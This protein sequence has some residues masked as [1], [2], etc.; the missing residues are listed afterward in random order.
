MAD[1]KQLAIFCHQMDKALHAGVDV[2][3]AF[4]IIQDDNNRSLTAAISRTYE[5]LRRGQSLS[6]SMRADESAYSSELVDLIYITEQTG[7]TELAFHRMAERFD[8]RLQIERKLKQAAIYPT[9]V[10]IVAIVSLL[11]VAYVYHMLPAA[12]ASILVFFGIIAAILFMKYS[13]D[14][15]SR[16]SRIVGN[17]LIRVPLLGKRIMQAELADLADNLAVFYSCGTGVDKALEFCA[18]ALRHEALREKVL[19]AASYVRRG[20][21]LSEALMM[22]GIFPPDLIHSIAVGEASG[23]VDAMLTKVA[24]YYRLEIEERTDRMMSILR[25]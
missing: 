15:V 1:T 10:V 18:K 23:S 12:I 5:G 3:R 25:M 9:I 8:R 19:K 24:E 17:V 4:L 11:A 21:P 20:N 6:L 16:S 13:A 22:Q 7:N 14:T 2:E